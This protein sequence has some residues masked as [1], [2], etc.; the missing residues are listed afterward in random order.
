VNYNRVNS[1][2]NRGGFLK[3]E[4]FGSLIDLQSVHLKAITLSAFLLLIAAP[5]CASEK[6]PPDRIAIASIDKLAVSS[7]GD[8]G[9]RFQLHV[10]A[11][12]GDILRVEAICG[13][14]SGGAPAASVGIRPIVHGAAEPLAAVPFMSGGAISNTAANSVGLWRATATGD[15]R[16]DLET[17]SAG[18]LMPCTLMAYPIGVT[19]IAQEQR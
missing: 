5:V 6:L 15:L 11:T 14:E 8:L 4:F 7:A 3:T 18:I 16:I 1:I 9:D 17:S 12:A 10:A 2:D 13:L 19:L